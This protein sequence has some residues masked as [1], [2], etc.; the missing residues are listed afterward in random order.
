MKITQYLITWDFT[1]SASARTNVYQNL[2]RTCEGTVK[3]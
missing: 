2:M 3:K 1:A